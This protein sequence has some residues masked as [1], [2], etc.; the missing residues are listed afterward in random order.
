[1]SPRGQGTE[2][3]LI[4]FRGRLLVQHVIE[5]LQAQVGSILLNTR[6]DQAPWPAFELPLVHDLVDGFAGPLAGLQAGLAACTTDWLIM[7]PC[8]T[9]LLP[10]DLVDGLV[11]AQ[12]ETGVERL[13]VRRGDQAHPVFALVHRQ[14]AADL[15]D[16]LASGGR[17]IEDWLARGPW[18][19]V[20]FADAGAFV[21]LNTMDE[22]CRLEP[23]D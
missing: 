20:D 22:L 5:R 21:N 19:Q 12:R 4:P 14:V 18:Q 10:L 17:K 7:V 3:A 23:H 8:D 1:M 9:P 13:S 2:K 6:S 11:R 15:A 16:F